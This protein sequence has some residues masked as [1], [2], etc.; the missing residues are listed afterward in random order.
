MH[1]LFEISDILTDFFSVIGTLFVVCYASPIIIAVV[2]PLIVI[3]FIIQVSYFTSLAL[4]CTT[5]RFLISIYV[6][7]SLLSKWKGIIQSREELWNSKIKLI[8]VYFNCC[9]ETKTW[10]YKEKSYEIRKSNRFMFL[11]ESTLTWSVTNACTHWDFKFI[12]FWPLTLYVL[13]T[14]TSL[15]FFQNSYLAVS[16]QLKRMVSVTRSPINSS[17]TESYSGAP[18]IRAYKMEEI[19]I[20]ENSFRVEANQQCYYPEVASNS[21]LFSRLEMLSNLVIWKLNKAQI[22][23]IDV[24]MIS[25]NNCPF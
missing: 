13:I 16:R 4:S 21:W 12:L 23:N 19:F 20:E 24:I 3:F 11:N 1:F 9:N 17:L 10:K 7:S 18:T 6:S 2:V 8:L 5:L 14:I 25:F 22:T 15:L